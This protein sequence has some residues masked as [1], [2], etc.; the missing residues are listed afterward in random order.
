MIIFPHNARKFV[1]VLTKS[2]MFKRNMGRG[3]NLWNAFK[4]IIKKPP[5]PPAHSST[6][7]NNNAQTRNY[8]ENKL[9]DLVNPAGKK[10]GFNNHPGIET[11][12][13]HTLAKEDGSMENFTD[14]TTRSITHAKKT[15]EGDTLAI[16]YGKDLNNNNLNQSLNPTPH[17]PKDSLIRYQTDEEI[18][19]K[20][21]N[22]L[23]NALEA[24]GR[25]SKKENHEIVKELEIKKKM[26]EIARNKDEP[27]ES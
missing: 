19:K 6:P 10:K 16:G 26:Q 22:T 15:S 14:R 12:E 17:S 5:N 13:S 4:N 21:P 9:V 25:L 20:N 7:I 23:K 1:I 3:N 18:Q 27:T 24:S 11:T 8:Q 2:Y